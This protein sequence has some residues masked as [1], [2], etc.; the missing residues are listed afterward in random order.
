MDRAR[1]Y[2]NDGYDVDAVDNI[3]E[4]FQEA[5]LW[6]NEKVVRFHGSPERLQEF[7]RAVKTVEEVKKVHTY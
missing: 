7:L 2:F 3:C 6:Y 5:D 1:I 4:Q